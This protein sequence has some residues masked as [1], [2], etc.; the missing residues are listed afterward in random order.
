[1]RVNNEMTGIRNIVDRRTR[2]GETYQRGAGTF[3]MDGQPLC[4]GTIQDASSKAFQKYL[5]C[6]TCGILLSIDEAKV[7]K[8][9]KQIDPNEDT[10][11]VRVVGDWM[12]QRVQIQHKSPGPPVIRKDYSDDVSTVT[13]AAETYIKAQ[14][15]FE[16]EVK[17]SLSERSEPSRHRLT[18]PVDPGFKYK[19]FLSGFGMQEPW[20]KV[21]SQGERLWLPSRA[22]T[23][24]QKHILEDVKRV[25]GT[26][27]KGKELRG[28]GPQDKPHYVNREID[29]RALK[30]NLKR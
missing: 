1:M 6:G 19:K 12:N 26:P 10:F 28:Y 13:S 24:R 29:H 21:Y 16:Q 2:N 18:E 30:I 5:L 17:L 14:E 15:M 11:M 7:C 20:E 4:R 8:K 23:S 27:S 22:S 3:I 9:C 25:N